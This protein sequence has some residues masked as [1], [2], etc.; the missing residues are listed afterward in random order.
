M[1]KIYLRQVSVWALL[2]GLYLSG[3]SSHK[4]EETFKQEASADYTASKATVEADTASINPAIEPG[5]QFVRT[6]DLKFRVKDVARTT[7]TIEM[8]TGKYGGFITQN[9]LSS[10]EVNTFSVQ[11]SADSLL[12]TTEYRVENNLSLRVPNPYLDELLHELGNQVTFLDY[13][14][15][16]ADDVSLQLLE[17]KLRIKRADQAGQ[18]VEQAIDHRGKKLGESL[19]GEGDL[20]ALQGQADASTLQNLSLTDQVNYSTVKLNLYQRTTTLQEKVAVPIVIP[21]YKP[22]LASQL[23]DAFLSGWSILEALLVGIVQLC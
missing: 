19:Q 18:R 12:E 10:A 9:H 5:R 3:C 4:A 7:H 15:V 13:R 2:A 14:I 11:I 22:S 23:T 1:R 8:L 20:L 21:A 6:A 17:N 16:N